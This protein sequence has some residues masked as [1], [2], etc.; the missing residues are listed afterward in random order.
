[1]TQPKEAGALGQ[2]QAAEQMPYVVEERRQG[3]L[4]ALARPGRKGVDL[5]VRN[6]KATRKTCMYAGMYRSIYGNMY[7]TCIYVYTCITC[8]CVRTYVGRKVG[9]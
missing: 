5:K 4:G 2:S 9:R 7:N 6:S 8:T 1:M 3:R